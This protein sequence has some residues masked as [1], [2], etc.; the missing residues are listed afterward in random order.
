MDHWDSLTTLRAPKSDPLRKW[1]DME[2]KSP[3]MSEDL[4]RRHVANRPPRRNA[5]ALLVMSGKLIAAAVHA[6]LTG[7]R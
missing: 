4:Y 6:W 2:G 1:A 7:S 3:T 5:L